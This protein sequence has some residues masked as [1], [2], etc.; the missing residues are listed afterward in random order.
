MSIRTDLS[1]YNSGSKRWGD[2]AA[3][4]R[5]LHALSHGAALSASEADCFAGSG[6]AENTLRRLR[7]CGYGLHRD[8]KGSWT[9]DGAVASVI[10]RTWRTAL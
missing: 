4:S 8:K 9:M 2:I 10:R 7:N 1:G 3:A 5:L 6:N